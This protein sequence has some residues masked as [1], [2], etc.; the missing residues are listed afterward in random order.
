MLGCSVVFAQV[1]INSL[2][3]SAK[4]LA[5]KVD[6]TIGQMDYLSFSNAEIRINE[7]VHQPNEF[8]IVTTNNTFS[9]QSVI[10]YPNP[11]TSKFNLCSKKFWNSVAFEVLNL[12][13][14]K[15]LEGMLDQEITELNLSEFPNGMYYIR[16][17][18]SNHTI[19]IQKIIK[20][21]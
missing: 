18:E 10:I 11:G 8:Q 9:D 21:N 5:G 19:Q 2:G 12:Q 14:N 15:I 3:Q 20:S 17:K 7:G 13:G 4:S 1:S 16:I 6:F